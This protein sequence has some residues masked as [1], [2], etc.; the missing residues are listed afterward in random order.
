MAASTGALLTR[1]PGGTATGERIRSLLLDP[2]LPALSARAEVLLILAARAQHVAE[3]IEPALAAGRDV[4][5]DRFSGSTLA[6]QGFG[7][8]LDV[9][10]LSTMSRW[11]AGGTEP[12]LVLLLEVPLDEAAARLHRRGGS[13]RME[14][15]E[16]RFFGRV[17]AGFAQLAASDPRRWRV[18]DGSG[19]VAEVA[20]RVKSVLECP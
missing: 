16:N 3:V 9:S 17:A 15:E 4:V 18:V 19:T 8:G 5:C 2:Y 7:R 14:G 13:D 1:E 10:E 11:A 6:Y 12:D 20:S